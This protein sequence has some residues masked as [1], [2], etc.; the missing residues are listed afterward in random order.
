MASEGIRFNN[1]NVESQ[2]TPSRSATNIEQWLV[3]A[4]DNPRTL[5]GIYVVFPRN[6]RKIEGLLHHDGWSAPIQV[7][8][9]REGKPIIDISSA[10]E[11]EFR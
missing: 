8:L 7:T 9:T 2:C 1:Y 6:V 3:G 11:G 4:T 5:Y 10:K